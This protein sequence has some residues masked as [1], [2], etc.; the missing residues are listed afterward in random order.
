MVW[1]FTNLD[2]INSGARSATCL[3]VLWLVGMEIGN[4][5][6]FGLPQQEHWS[7]E[8][9]LTTIAGSGLINC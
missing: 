6:E 5:M 9:K 8:P 1:Q 2:R 3:V 4:E 7:E